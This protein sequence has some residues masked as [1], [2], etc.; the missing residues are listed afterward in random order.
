LKKND[1]EEQEKE[2]E[3]GNQ[4][5]ASKRKIQ[6][7]AP[8]AT[9]VSMVE[10]AK[11][12]KAVAAEGALCP[13]E[14]AKGTSATLVAEEERKMP[15]LPKYATV[16]IEVFG[17]RPVAVEVAPSLV[18]VKAI[19]AQGV[20]GEKMEKVEDEDKE[21]EDGDDDSNSGD[22]EEEELGNEGTD[23]P[24]FEEGSEGKVNLAVDAVASDNLPDKVKPVQKVSSPFDLPILP[25]AKTLLVKQ[26]KKG[27]KVP[28]GD[29]ESILLLIDDEAE[30]ATPLRS[31]KKKELATKSPA[32]GSSNKV[33]TAK[34]SED[35]LMMIQGAQG[36]IFNLPWNSYVSVTFLFNIYLNV[37]VFIVVNVIISVYKPVYVNCCINVF[38]FVSTCLCK[39]LSKCFC[40]CFQFCLV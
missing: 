3:A 32:A 35:V 17:A 36:E 31:Q 8:L 25:I 34:S 18:A 20:T 28:D 14:V 24:P 11:K 39:L 23:S 37:Y 16:P 22:D 13:P 26:G 38:V 33:G 19:E 15:S 10:K 12:P 5:R 27:K 9:T 21:D 7:S 29:E 4:T 6:Q 1:E 40:I 2:D 30:E